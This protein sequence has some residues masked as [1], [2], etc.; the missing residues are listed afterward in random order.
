MLTL[1]SARSTEL[2]LRVSSSR[3]VVPIQVRRHGVPQ[4]DT[5]L[6][7]LNTEALMCHSISWQI[8]IGGSERKRARRERG[9]LLSK[10]E[11]LRGYSKPED[12]SP[13]PSRE[14]PTVAGDG[15]PGRGR[16]FSLSRAR[17]TP[18]GPPP[19]QRA[20]REISATSVL[21]SVR[22]PLRRAPLVPH[23]QASR[24]GENENGDKRAANMGKR[25]LAP[26]VANSDVIDVES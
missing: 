6:R 25:P 16:P 11:L 5:P 3:Q 21:T 19:D 8:R 20:D 18:G 2:I 15:G 9:L 24:G 12:L 10:R 14:E 22:R 7:G 26:A 13:S 23:T 1:R 4:G 17:K